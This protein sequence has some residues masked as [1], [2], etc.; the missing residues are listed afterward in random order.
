[1]SSRASTGCILTYD[2]EEQ[3]RVVPV[4]RVPYHQLADILLESPHR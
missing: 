3:N 4:W 2:I 1:M